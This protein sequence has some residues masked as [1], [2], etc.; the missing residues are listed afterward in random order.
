MI[1]VFDHHV[2][3]QALVLYLDPIVDLFL[4]LDLGINLV[5]NDLIVNLVILVILSSTSSSNP[6]FDIDLVPDLVHAHAVWIK[7]CY[8]VC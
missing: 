6:S 5:L 2:H 7:R 1:F 3:D 8:V 4:D